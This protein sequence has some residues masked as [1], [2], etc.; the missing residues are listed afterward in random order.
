MTPKDTAILRKYL[1]WAQG[2]LGFAAECVEQSDPFRRT[3]VAI[4]IDTAS[5][6]TK[7]ALDDLLESVTDDGI[8]EDERPPLR[9]VIPDQLAR[10][11]IPGGEWVFGDDDQEE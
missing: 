9:G 2:L 1:E 10:R 3:T 8:E 7:I 4:A 11:M 5:K 6:A